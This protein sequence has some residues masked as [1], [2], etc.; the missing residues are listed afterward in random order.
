MS[1]TVDYDLTIIGGGLVGATLALSL[2]DSGLRIAL[3]EAVD[4]QASSQPS[5]DDRTLVLNR[6]SCD[7]LHQADL[8]SAVSDAATASSRV[9]S[10][11]KRT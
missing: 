7:W 3:V 6:V 4:R 8:W 5:Y 9:F 2:R 10:R 1:H 11:T